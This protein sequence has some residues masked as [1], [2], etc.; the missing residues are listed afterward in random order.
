MADLPAARYTTT[1]DGTHTHTG[2]GP[3]GLVTGQTE[4]GVGITFD[5]FDEVEKGDRGKPPVTQRG[6]FDRVIVC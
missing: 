5:L 1:R 3:C 4:R 2:T 6:F